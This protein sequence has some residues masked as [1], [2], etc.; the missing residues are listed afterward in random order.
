[1]FNDNLS[2]SEVAALLETPVTNIYAL[3]RA[4]ILTNSNHFGKPI[5]ISEAKVRWYLNQ[6]VPSSF[7]VVHKAEVQQGVA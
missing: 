4:G 3:V 7:R 2:V 5:K 1:M 6:R